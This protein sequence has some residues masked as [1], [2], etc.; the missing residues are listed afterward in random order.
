MLGCACR[1]TALSHVTNPDV[2][3]SGTTLQ[4][5][6]STVEAS[7]S[8][9]TVTYSLT[10]AN[11]LSSAAMADHDRLRSLTINYN[12]RSPAGSFTP[13]TVSAQTVSRAGSEIAATFPVPDSSEDIQPFLIYELQ[14]SLAVQGQTG[15]LSDT[16]TF[17]RSLQGVD[18]SY[19]RR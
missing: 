10:G 8:E 16:R 18:N 12:P 15:P 14:L 2:L 5:Q 4:P 13:I 11:T 17:I 3:P 9:I 1:G 19:T 7:A 6:V